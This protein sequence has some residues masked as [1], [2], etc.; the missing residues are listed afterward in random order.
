MFNIRRPFWLLVTCFDP[1]GWLI[2]HPLKFANLGIMFHIKLGWMGTKRSIQWIT[3]WLLIKSKFVHVLRLD[4]QYLTIMSPYCAS[5]NYI[6][7]TLIFYEWWSTFWIFVGGPWLFMWRDAHI[8]RIKK[9]RVA[10]NVD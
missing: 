9:H 5:L 4:I 7:L 8:N 10:P 6:K 3:L 1:L 2:A